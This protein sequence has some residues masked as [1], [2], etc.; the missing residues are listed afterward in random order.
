[1]RN[2]KPINLN[3]FLMLV[4]VRRF[5]KKYE[6]CRFVEFTAI[7]LTGNNDNSFFD[8]LNVQM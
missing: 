6:S 8:G 1:M 4:L 2:K 7:F 3:S 5:A